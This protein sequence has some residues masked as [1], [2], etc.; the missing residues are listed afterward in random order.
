M[1]VQYWHDPIQESLYKDKSIF[2]ADINNE[3]IPRNESYKQNLIKLKNLVLVKYLNDS[4]VDP[5]ETEIFGFYK[6]G[7]AKD[8]YTMRESPLYQ[9][10]WIGLKELDTSGRLHLYEVIGDHL[11]FDMQ[12]FEKEIVEKFLR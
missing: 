10:D 4:I 11:Q 2:L 8:V 7:Q 12:W 5:R 1:Y 9:E 6:A 3:N